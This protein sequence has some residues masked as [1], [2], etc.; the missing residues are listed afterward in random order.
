MTGEPFKK[1]DKTIP[2]P[3][4]KLT[5]DNVHPQ[6]FPLPTFMKNYIHGKVNSNVISK[7]QQTSKFYRKM[8]PFIICRRLEINDGKPNGYKNAMNITLEMIQK[9]PEIGLTNSLFIGESE[10]SQVKLIPALFSKITFC[11]LKYIRIDFHNNLSFSEFKVLTKSGN[12]EV[13]HL[14]L[15]EILNDEGSRIPLD[16]LLAHVSKVTHFW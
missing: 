11:D 2:N 5:L 16:V 3:V 8:F 12:V 14:K 9:L 6:K 13:L 7:L 4:Q 10:N 15:I 1:Q